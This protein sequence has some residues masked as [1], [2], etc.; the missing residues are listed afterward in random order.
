MPDQKQY[1]SKVKMAD[2]TVYWI[3]DAAVAGNYL[4]LTGGELTGDITLKDTTTGDTN[5]TLTTE[6]DI[7]AKSLK[8]EDIDEKTAAVSN[9]L[10]LD[11]DDSIKFHS[12]DDF[13]SE[14]GGYSAKVQNE[15]L[16]LK[17]GKE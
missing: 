8:L 7:I 13:L 17:L 2:G 16:K 12:T 11:D 14:I 15:Q 3:K 6:G 5:I 1:I 9:V 4:P 10:T